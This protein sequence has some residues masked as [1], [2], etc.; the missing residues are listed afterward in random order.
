MRATE[1]RKSWKNIG[2]GRESDK[3]EDTDRKREREREG[4][5]SDTQSGVLSSVCRWSACGAPGGVP[6]LHS[7]AEQITPGT[8]TRADQ[9]S[10][11]SGSSCLR[12]ITCRS[13]MLQGSSQVGGGGLRLIGDWS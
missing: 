7:V 8:G 10:L 9:W 12:K 5:I 4:G 1:E 2:V 11:Q 6:S 13:Q 3:S